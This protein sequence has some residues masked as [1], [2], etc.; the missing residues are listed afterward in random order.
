MNPELTHISLENAFYTSSECFADECDTYFTQNW[1]SVGLASTLAPN[2]ISPTRIANIPILL[3]RTSRGELHAFHNACRH[4]GIKLVHDSCADVERVTCPYHA[5]TYDLSGEFLGAPYFSGKPGSN[6][7][8]EL[9]N[10]LGLRP[11][12]HH[13]WFDMIFV[14]L[15][16]TAPPFEDWIAPLA[17]YWRPF[18]E[19][20]I[21]LLSL[22]G[23]EV[24]ANWKLV[25]E[26]FLDNYHVPFVHRQAGG[27]RTA[28]NYENIT[29]SPD[30]FGFTLPKGELDKPK[31]DWLPTLDL[32]EDLRD[33]QF[34]FCLFPNTLIAITASWFQVISV[35]ANAANR[36]SEFLGLYAMAEIPDEGRADADRF[37]E[38]MNRINQ[39]DI[40]LLASLQE[41]RG[42]PASEEGVLAPYWDECVR[43]FHDRIRATP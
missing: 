39:Q 19:S 20:R 18:D 27:P 11:I 38:V 28:V 33:A 35:Q 36:S 30:I 17:E 23:Y 24:D 8:G 32:D 29:L 9:K 13:V 41:G 25:C 31:A 21:R 12:R 7:P 3:T 22:T 40:E 2:S 43:R 16:G 37:S 42:S 10:A 4:R 26:N 1:V 5:W 15:S 34:F 6:V 14:D